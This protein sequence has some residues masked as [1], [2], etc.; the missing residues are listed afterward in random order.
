MSTEK[1]QQATILVYTCAIRQAPSSLRGYQPSLLEEAKTMDKR[2]LGA[3]Q[4]HQTSNVSGMHRSLSRVA[5]ARVQ[6]LTPGR[7]GEA[8]KRGITGDSDDAPPSK[9]AKKNGM[10]VDKRPN[11]AKKG[12]ATDET[13]TDSAVMSRPPPKRKQ[14]RGEA[15]PSASHECICAQATP[16]KQANLRTPK[17]PSEPNSNSDIGASRLA[18]P[19]G[20]VSGG[21]LFIFGARLSD[22][23]L[24][25]RICDRRAMPDAAGRP[26]LMSCSGSPPSSNARVLKNPREPQPYVWMMM[27]QYTV[28]QIQNSCNTTYLLAYLPWTGPALYPTRRIHPDLTHR[29]SKIDLP[30]LDSLS[31]PV[32]TSIQGCKRRK[33]LLT[34]GKTLIGDL[35][36]L[37]IQGYEYRRSLL[38]SPRC[39]CETG[40]GVQDA[41]SGGAHR[42]SLSRSRTKKEKPQI[43]FLEEYGSGHQEDEDEDMHV[44][45]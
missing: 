13:D 41:D 29:P 25:I 10:V 4:D 44:S 30:I 27:L 45:E 36:E 26:F 11:M 17:K 14:S 32:I 21:H 12:K 1:I 39:Q 9:R 28:V 3:L 23:I 6:M 31:R 24:D 15:A 37:S 33:L 19:I 22:S 16:A 40:Y 20:K 18:K 35:K 5:R 38:Q 8:R 43:K 34:P 42:R 2:T 7:Q